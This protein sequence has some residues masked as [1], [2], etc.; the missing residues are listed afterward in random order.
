MITIE[1]KNKEVLDVLH[2]MVSRMHDLRPALKEIGEDM[3]ESTKR[4]FVT[5][6]APDGTPWEANSPVTLERYLGVFVN[7][8]KKD[9]TLS[10]AG[11]K[12]LGNKKPLTGETHALAGGINYQVN[13]SSSV[14]IGSPMVYAAMQHFGGTTEQFPH[15]WGDIPARP[16]L[17]V[18]DADSANIVDIVSSYLVAD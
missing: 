15:L 17:G 18:S 1:V 9:G 7:S 3:V 10:K 6:T 4:R 5:A 14:G 12:R 8:H 11:E 16:I 2:Q 13:G